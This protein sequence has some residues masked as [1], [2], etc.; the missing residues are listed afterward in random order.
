MV[1]RS[2]LV[3]MAVATSVAWAAIAHAETAHAATAPSAPRLATAPFVSPALLQWT[4]GADPA[5]LLQTVFRA[6]GACTQPPT[7]ATAVRTYSDNTTAQ[8][9]AQPGDGTFCFSIGATDV[10]GATAVGP[11]LTVTIDTTPPTATVAVS[12]QAAG[13]VVQGTVRITRT[14]ADAVSGVASSVLHVGPVGA[15]AS[16]PAAGASW[17]T[18]TYANGSYD[19]CNVVT[20]RAGLVTTALVTVTVANPVPPPAPLAPALAPSAVA[21][22]LAVAPSAPVLVGAVDKDAP[23]APSRLAVVLPR[24]KQGAAKLVPLTLRWVNPKAA[25]LARVVVILNLK[26]APRSAKDGNVVYNGL[27]TSAVFKLHPGKSGYVAL[28]AYDRAGNV[29]APA[30]RT[31]SLAALIPLRPLTG[32]LVST[33]PRMT[34]Q[35]EAG[36]AYYNIQVFRNGRRVLVGWPSAASYQLP[37]YLLQPGVYTWFVWPAFKHAGAAPTFGD[38]IGRATFVF[39]K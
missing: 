32:T 18:T 23:G 3:T 19:V 13:G 25:D 9:F 6:P 16:G 5:N 39:Q 17:D 20:D 33:P 37:E 27:R 24:A 21:P 38:L 22:S 29:S 14:S 36:V 8:H 31:V 35:A 28:F 15:C 2:F 12:S 11:G 1:R 4:P 7:A 26:H 10:L 34:W 30:R